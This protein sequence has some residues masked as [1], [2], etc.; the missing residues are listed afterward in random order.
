MEGGGA[1]LQSWRNTAVPDM[2]R[3]RSTAPT[4][5]ACTTLAL[6]TPA[7]QVGALERGQRPL[8]SAPTT[9]ASVITATVVQ[10]FKVGAILRCRTMSGTAVLRQLERLAQPWA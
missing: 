4:L 8:S 9:V 6:I 2:V 10:T 3:N 1:R 5:N 7:M